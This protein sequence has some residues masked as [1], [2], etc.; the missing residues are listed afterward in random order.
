M[1]DN[2]KNFFNIEN[3]TKY[4]VHIS[5]FLLVISIII[6]ALLLL[7]NQSLNQNKNVVQNTKPDPFSDLGLEAKSVVVWDTVNERAIFF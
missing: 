2:F 5:I 1:S 4:F 6:F 3:R 7:G